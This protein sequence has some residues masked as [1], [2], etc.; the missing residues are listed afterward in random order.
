MARRS[1]GAGRPGAL[2]EARE[3]VALVASLSEAGDAL[4]PQAVSARLGVSAERA[5]KLIELVLTATGVDGASLP[6]MEEDGEFTLVF[7]QGMRGR[8]LRLTRSETLALVAALERLGV[9]EGDPLRARLSQSLSRESVDEGVVERLLGSANYDEIGPT[10][11]LCAQAIAEREG[12]SFSYQKSSD[13]APSVRRAAPQGLRHEDGLWY[14][15][16]LDLDRVQTRT[17]RLDRMSD[18]SLLTRSG[19]PHIDWA[20]EARTVKI[21]FADARYLDL[22]PWHALSHVRRSR[23]GGSATAET[24]YYGGMWLPRMIAACAGTATTND[25]ELN[26]LVEQYAREQLD[27]LPR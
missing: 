10:L 11:S 12:I 25:Q 6:L 4:T 23:D 15:D 26:K 3:L 16:A 19:E 8:R 1:A 24:P 20:P 14:L 22:L 18:V 17:F 5:E 21:T 7:S 9:D 27:K 2:D 13:A